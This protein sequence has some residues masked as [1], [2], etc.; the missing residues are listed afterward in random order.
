MKNM[1]KK[2]VVVMMA[3]AMTIMSAMSA[4][5]ATYKAELY[6]IGND[7]TCQYSEH[8]DAMTKSITKT[9]TGYT[10]VFQPITVQ[11]G[12]TAVQG[13]ISSLTASGATTSFNEDTKELTVNIT[14]SAVE[15]TAVK[16]GET[17]VKTGTPITYSIATGSFEHPN[18]SGYLVIVAE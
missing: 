10:I 14:P 2:L 7:G 13:Y 16:D 12:A 8:S 6:G 11:M 9:R 4:F 18:T 15:F 5:A 3:L 1:N 17:V